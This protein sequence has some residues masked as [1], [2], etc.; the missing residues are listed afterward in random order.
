MG[1]SIAIRRKFIQVSIRGVLLSVS[2]YFAEGS[3]VTH[4]DVRL[5]R[6]FFS[7]RTKVPPAFVPPLN[8]LHVSRGERH[9]PISG[10]ATFRPLIG[11]CESI[12]YATQPRILRTHHPPGHGQVGLLLGTPVVK[13][14]HNSRTNTE[15]DFTPAAADRMNARLYSSGQPNWLKPRRSINQYWA[16]WIPIRILDYQVRLPVLRCRPRSA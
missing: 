2:V 11:N 4:R 7:G 14:V 15:T 13:P 5:G 16:V 8:P 3:T 10:N 12:G 1:K 9:K 6:L